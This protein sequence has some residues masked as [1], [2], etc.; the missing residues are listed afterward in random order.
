MPAALYLQG[1]NEEGTTLSIK[2]ASFTAKQFI[3]SRFILYLFLF[4]PFFICAQDKVGKTKTEIKKQL[5]T[6]K[7]ANRSLSPVITDAATTSTLT[8]KD[9][10]YGLVKFIY[11]FNKSKICTSEKTVATNDSARTNLLNTVLEQPVHEWKKINGNQYISK[12][13]DKLMIEIP[14]KPTDHSF[15]IYKADWTKEVYDMLNRK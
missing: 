9:P 11:T 15:T 8:I 13:S 10:A 1:K 5:D 12:F 7:T 14:G 6:W 3:M 2:F 4:S